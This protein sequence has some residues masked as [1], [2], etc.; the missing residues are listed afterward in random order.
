ME[1]LSSASSPP[2]CTT[3]SQEDWEIFQSKV[4]E[5]QTMART[6]LGRDTTE[7]TSADLLE[8]METFAAMKEELAQ[9]QR[10]S[11]LTQQV[12]VATQ[13]SQTCISKR[14]DKMVESEEATVVSKDD[15][16][17]EEDHPELLPE[18]QA[19][20]LDED[21]D[22]EDSEMDVPHPEAN[23]DEDD[24]EEGS[25][26]DVP[27]PEANLDEEIM[28]I[29]PT[30]SQSLGVGLL[31]DMEQCIVEWQTSFEQINAQHEF[32]VQACQA[33][34][35]RLHVRIDT[36]KALNLTG[37]EAASAAQRARV[38]LE[39]LVA[40]VEA[41]PSKARVKA[42]QRKLKAS[43]L[44]EEDSHEALAR[45]MEELEAAREREE[46]LLRRLEEA[47]SFARQFAESPVAEPKT[48]HEELE[49]ARE[50]EED[51]LRR[52][53]EAESFARQFAESPVAEPK[54]T[55]TVPARLLRFTKKKL[56]RLFR[57]DRSARRQYQSREVSVEVASS[58]A[59]H[60]PAMVSSTI[61]SSSEEAH[62][63]YSSDSGI[64]S[65]SE[66]IPQVS[67][68]DMELQKLGSSD[69]DLLLVF[70]ASDHDDSSDDEDEVDRARDHAYEHDDSSDE[71]DRARDYAYEEQS[72]SDSLD[73]NYLD[74]VMLAHMGNYSPSKLSLS[75]S[76]D[77]E[78]EMD[79]SKVTT[80][81]TIISFA[82]DATTNSSS[83]T[84]PSKLATKTKKEVF[85][86]SESK[87]IFA[88][89]KSFLWIQ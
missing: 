85:V 77:D 71:V 9:L 60:H 45:A 7:L 70:S 53:E 28:M 64:S 31:G 83:G 32:Q 80:D 63:E 55:R 3:F 62:L 6:I 35:E 11:Q 86:E 81:D 47:E 79:L 61:P 82:T 42:L 4:L 1:E 72:F 41:F 58:Q 12:L 76:M 30:K 68:P 43:K 66:T 87:G 37:M 33:D 65:T 74:E 48:T 20:E 26:M 54:T 38:Q 57:L 29:L 17:S 8:A 21:D 19:P 5:A 52:L 15:S 10:E 25:E 69:D 13:C 49:A 88:K 44:A 75:S 50:R 22:E 84:P 89:A 78:C 40:I 16:F 46:D 59:D 24:D 18:Q 27:H 36:M 23:L 56:Q 51:L 2:L 14:L 67:E 34:L 39:K 73:T